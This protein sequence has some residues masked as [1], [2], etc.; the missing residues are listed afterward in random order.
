V[1]FQGWK[2]KSPERVTTP[3]PDGCHLERGVQSIFEVNGMSRRLLRFGVWGGLVAAVL[4]AATTR[5]ADAIGFDKGAYVGYAGMVLAFLMVFFG[6]RSYRDQELGGAIGFWRALGAGTVIVL[7][8]SVF[9]VV[10][11]EILYYN[12]MPDFLDKYGAY[13]AQKAQAAGAS[14]EKLAAQAAALARYKQIYANPLLNGAMTLTEPLPV[15]LAVALISAA[16]L[17]KKRPA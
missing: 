16:V 2:A 17:R 14:P 4:M 1:I 9:Y 8:T 12:F 10:A 15:G 6:V 11:W 7:I 13:M 5:F 3:G